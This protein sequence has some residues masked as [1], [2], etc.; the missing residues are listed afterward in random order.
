MLRKIIFKA[1]AITLLVIS[2]ALAANEANQVKTPAAVKA[3]PKVELVTM[4]DF[5]LRDGNA[6]SGKLL[7]DDKTQLVVEQPQQNTVVVK[8]YT[9]KD[10]DT[11]T[12]SKRTMPESQYYSHL[13]EYFAAQAWDFRDDPDEFIQAIRCY[14]KAK[15]SLEQSGAE[16][17]KIAEADA[18]LRKI[19]ADK[20]TWTAQ[21][22]SRAKLKQLEYQAEAENR[23]KLLEKDIAESNAKLLESIKYLDK[24][25][26]DIRNDYNRLEKGVTDLN[27]DFV[28]QVKNLQNQIIDNRTAINDLSY[29]LF[30]VTRGG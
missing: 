17:E 13:G 27:K 11:R 6:V 12:V 14:E 1:L 26:A 20:E 22:E 29:R 21:V 4:V 16:P 3:K 10:V 30:L 5:Y 19:K 25:A 15:I 28:E 24:T 2:I 18:A 9:K 7:S 23:L 8:T